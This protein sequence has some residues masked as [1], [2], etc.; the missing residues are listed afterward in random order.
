MRHT[1]VNAN[2]TVENLLVEVTY[3]IANDCGVDSQAVMNEVDN[4]LKTGLIAATT[5]TTIDILNTTYPRAGDDNRRQ[6]QRN[7]FNL[8]HSGDRKLVQ[9]NGALDHTL[10]PDHRRHLVY[11]TGEL[12]V[13][14]DNVIDVTEDCPIGNNCLLIVSTITTVLEEGDNPDEVKKAL[15]D[16]IRESFTDG[17]FYANIPA[18][19]VICP[20]ERRMRRLAAGIKVSLKW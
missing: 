8:R 10:S 11:Y 3:D 14:M 4:T 19:T 5:T 2:L 13:T 18:D 17:S 20:G 9:L 6:L 16:G 15:E 1:D 12:P 7:S